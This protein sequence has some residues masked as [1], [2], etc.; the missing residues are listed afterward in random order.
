[1][2]LLKSIVFIGAI[3]GQSC[4]GIVGDMI[5]ISKGLMITNAL[6]IVG[7]SMT[8]ISLF[9]SAP[10]FGDNMDL[11]YMMLVFARAILGVGIGGN[12]PLASGFSAEVADSNAKTKTNPN[13][14]TMES[15]DK[16]NR[17]KE[18]ANGFFWQ[19]P[20]A[21]LPY[22]VSLALLLIMG[23]NSTGREHLLTTNFQF[24]SLVGIGIIPSLIVLILVRN[25]EKSKNMKSYPRYHDRIRHEKIS[26][27]VAINDKQNQKNLFGCSACWFLYDVVLYGTSVNLPQILS[28]VFTNESEDLIASSWHDLVVSVLGIPGILC[29]L[30][31]LDYFGVKQLQV[32]GFVAIGIASAGL[33]LSLSG[34]FSTGRLTLVLLC[35]ALMFSLSWGCSLSTYVLPMEVFDHNIRSSFHGLSAASGKLGGFIGMCALLM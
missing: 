32:A 17:A 1:M 29:A 18:V 12:Y 33:S 26:L 14:V 23:K 20:G 24:V 6:I 2:S 9:L 8:I 11:L 30:Y 31:S 34:I 3:L 25:Y 27:K 28:Y 7:V 21:I 5:G 10:K 19:T 13:S 35:C 16:N 4:F 22:I 15:G